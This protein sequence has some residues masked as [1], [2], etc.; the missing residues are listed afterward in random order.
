MLAVVTARDFISLF[1]LRRNE[2]A[3]VR[4][5]QCVNGGKEKSANE[6]K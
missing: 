2:R 4:R 6:K 5:A 1:T 3:G